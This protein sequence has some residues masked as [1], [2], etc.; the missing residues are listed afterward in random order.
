MKTIQDYLRECNRDEV[1]GAYLYNYAFD[2]SLLDK[3]CKDVV[4]GE[5]ID[6]IKSN[7]NY[8]IDKLIS[9]EPRHGDDEMVFFAAYQ[10]ALDKNEVNFMLVKK[11]E[12]CQEGWSTPYSFILTPFEEAVSFYVADTYLTQYHIN[13]LLSFF[14]FEISFFGYE[15]EDVDKIADELNESVKE[16]EE[17]IDDDSYFTSFADFKKKM[18]DDFGFE[19][20][21]EDPDQKAAELELNKKIIEYNEYCQRLEI[22]KLKKLL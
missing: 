10:M 4:V 13:D 12:I 8:F 7:L 16:V 2:S 21:K 5:L 14:L 22:N 9:I 15:Q 3:D 17:H 6:S 11:D 1:I 20:E 18:E 19:F